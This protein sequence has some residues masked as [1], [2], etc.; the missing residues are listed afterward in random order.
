MS[1]FTGL[2]PG[3][4][5]VVIDFN[6]L[7]RGRRTMGEIF[8]DADYRTMGVFSAPYVHGHYG[9][10]RG[11]DYYERATQDA[12]LFDLPRDQRKLEA[13]LTEHRSHTEVTSGMVMDRALALLRNSN[14]PRNLLFLHFFDPHYDYRAP[15]RIAKAFTD[16]AYRGKVTGDNLSAIAGQPDLALA[17]LAPAD[18][19]QLLALYDAEL[20]W[21]DENIGRLLE[22][23]KAQG[24][25]EHTLIVVTGDHGEEFFEHGRFG[26]RNGLSEQTLHV[27]LIVW[28]PGLGVPAGRV[29]AET[30]AN[31]DILPTLI[32]YA[33][34]HEEPGLYGRSLRPLI[35]GGSL[36]VR[37]ISAA[38]TFMPREPLG[39]YELHRA[40][41]VNGWKLVSKVHVRW[42][43]ETE[44]DLGG[45]VIPGSEEVHVFDLAA[46]PLEEHDLSASEDP[47]V[48]AHVELVRGAWDAEWER[49]KAELQRFTP[50][51]TPAG[52]DSGLQLMEL[53]RANGYLG[54]DT[55]PQPAGTGR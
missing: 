4:H 27:P 41:A 17:S 24:R 54:P 32:D 37:P 6:V 39:Y 22:A 14:A 38:L 8:K 50:R 49:Q 31:Y 48:R 7:D 30:V 13:G 15:K 28:G 46:D 53:L 21:V 12:M 26:H 3:L 40:V 1:L 55:A 42:T 9:F 2:P 36:P 29:V 43:P 35:E 5:E 10:D 19:Q 45:E 11:F 20:A 18:R 23:L 51:G 34:L 44:R 16:P 33:G 25:L 47:Q 52:S